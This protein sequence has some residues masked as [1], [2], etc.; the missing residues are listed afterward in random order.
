MYDAYFMPEIWLKYGST[1]VVLDIKAENLLD[2]VVEDEQHMGEEAINAKLDTVSLNGSAHIAVLDHSLQIA[3]LSLLL[4]DSIKRRGLEN[5]SIDVPSG[6]LNIYK[7]IFQD[8]NVPISKLSNE[9]SDLDKAILLSKTSFDPL[10]GYSGA[11]T[12]L[13]RYF[14]KE[15]MLDAYKA[16]DS[17]MPTPGMPNKALS[18]AH[19]FAMLDAT[20]I[21]AVRGGN[22]FADI[23]VNEPVESHK[24]AISK[25]ESMGKVEVEKS[26]T[27]IISSG[28]GY[29]TLSYA[30]NS[31]WNCL[32][33]V[34]DDGSMT[35][36]AEC[37]D[38]FGSQALQMLVEGKI[39]MEDAYRPAEYIDGFENLLY[40]SEVSKKYNISL[41]SA[42]PDYY[43]KSR[44]GFKAFRR[45]KDVLHS[46]LNVYGPKQKILV[47]AD[48]SKILLKHKAPA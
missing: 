22:G 40:L 28:N 9:L 30:L 31:L 27:A 15:K 47:I 21:E 19:E 5:I 48:A 8:R 26:K 35:L 13:L 33:A 37:K 39:S 16:R 32:D 7:S 17:D 4:V 29:S 3:K 12:Y 44:L 34:K 14:G 2:Y 45:T 43:T 25:L 23:I 41:V 24:E 18:I 10:F 38:G 46:I 1:E 6:I 36:L 20:S 42:L 11:P